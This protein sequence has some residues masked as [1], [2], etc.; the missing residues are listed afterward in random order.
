MLGL[1]FDWMEPSV[2]SSMMIDD[3][4]NSLKS[5]HAEMTPC[6]TESAD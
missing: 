3:W 6:L 4:Q 1:G 2:I 5:P